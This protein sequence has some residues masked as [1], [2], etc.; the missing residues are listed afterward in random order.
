VK[1]LPTRVHGVFDYLL[2]IVWIL[3]PWLFGFSERG[4]ETWIPLCLGIGIL[5]YSACTAYEWGMLRIIPMQTHL[6]LDVFAGAFLAVSPFLFHFDQLVCVPH[7]ILG[8]V[9]V[10]MAGITRRRPDFLIDHNFPDP[11]ET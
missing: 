5:L 4:P 2:G 7:V 8:G 3:S 1:I 6:V 10:G 11:Y 9:L